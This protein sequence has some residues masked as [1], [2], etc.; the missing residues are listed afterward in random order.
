ME[1]YITTEWSCE[2]V[3]VVSQGTGFTVCRLPARFSDLGA[4]IDNV[5]S[6]CQ[7]EAVDSEI[8]SQGGLELRLWGP[9]T[10]AVMPSKAIQEETS[11]V[12]TVSTASSIVTQWR[13]SIVVIIVAVFMALWRMY[14]DAVLAEL[15]LYT[16]RHA[17]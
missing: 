7:V 2:G 15:H 9:G 14:G 17:N 10:T 12:A 13:A 11:Q 1:D 8:S 3:E 16:A 5:T 6:E 4:F